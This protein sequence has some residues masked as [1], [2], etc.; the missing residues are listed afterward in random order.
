M[1]WWVSWIASIRHTPLGNNRKQTR[2]RHVS[3]YRVVV[4]WCSLWNR[5]YQIKY[6]RT[7]IFTSLILARD[8]CINCDLLS[9]LGPTFY[10]HACRHIGNERKW[11]WRL[12]SMSWLLITEISRDGDI[13][14]YFWPHI[15]ICQKWRFTC[16]TAGDM[17]RLFLSPQIQEGLI[18]TGMLRHVI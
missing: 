12:S 11:V 18:I 9:Y 4:S 1:V 5:V 13:A 14:I 10:M 6:E 16:L 3:C 7:Q 15:A 17:H 8:L 2:W